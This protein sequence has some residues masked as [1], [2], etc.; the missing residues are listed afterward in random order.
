MSE[1]KTE[2]FIYQDL[3]FP[4][5]LI[6]A[7]MKKIYGQWFLD[8]NLSRLQK[9]ILDLL[10]HKPAPLTG[11]E[12]RFIRK[13]FEMTTTD[14][15]HF[16]GA[17]HAAVLKWEKGYSKM[18]PATEVYIRLYVFD[19]L[20]KKDKEFRKFYHEI[21]IDSFSKKKKKE[22][23]IVSLVVDACEDVLAYS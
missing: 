2:T 21:N 18:N 8:I 14:F 22:I 11:S 9:N 10:V 4:V 12:I 6:N 1:I 13:Y 5:K 15:G 16:C 3:G 7:P 23:E 19:R 20:R 17:T